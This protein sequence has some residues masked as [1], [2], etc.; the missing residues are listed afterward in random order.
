M[1]H[2]PKCPY[3]GIA[4]NNEIRCLPDGTGVRQVQKLNLSFPSRVSRLSYWETYCCGNWERCTLSK[5]ME[6]EYTRNHAEV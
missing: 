3:F 5:E 2:P 4:R 1:G 6:K